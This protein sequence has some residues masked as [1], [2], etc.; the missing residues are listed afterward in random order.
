M[1]KF[2]ILNKFYKQEKDNLESDNINKNKYEKITKENNDNYEEI[3]NNKICDED[4]ICV[5]V[6]KLKVYD[7]IV[8]SLYEKNFIKP[9]NLLDLIDLENIGDISEMDNDKIDG[10]V[11][12]IIFNNKDEL[13]STKPIGGMTTASKFKNQ[14]SMN[15]IIRGLK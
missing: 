4:T 8:T 5:E 13:V 10:V 6:N 12:S 2:P 3:E 7:K 14:I 9:K 1:K 11:N 15:E